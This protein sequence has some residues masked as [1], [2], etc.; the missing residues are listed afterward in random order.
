MASFDATFDAQED[1]MRTTVTIDDELLETAQKYTGIK[2]KSTL[3]RLGLESLVQREAAR[4]LARMGGSQ[5]GLEYIRRRRP[6][7]AE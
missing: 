3:I 2:E 4:R 6:E 7:A 5:P 1:Q